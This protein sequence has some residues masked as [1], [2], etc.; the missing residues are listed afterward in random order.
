MNGNTVLHEA[1]N[2]QGTEELLQYL[3]EKQ[4][5]IDETNNKGRTPLHYASRGLNLAAVQFLI[6][7]GAAIN[8][9]DTAKKTP[10]HLACEELSQIDEDEELEKFDQIIEYLLQQDGIEIN[11]Q[12]NEGRVPLHYICSDGT[13]EQIQEFCD[14]R[15]R[16]DI[17][18]N[19][20]KSVVH[21]AY[22]A[23]RR[24]TRACIS[25]PAT[26]RRYPL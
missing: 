12:D 5:P 10:L 14:E 7:A 6:E 22:T 24:A 17:V 3:A 13:M 15:A 21:Y 19:Y 1:S 4:L 23:E 11:S 26:E 18:D 8:S 2:G 9:Q 25:P 20:G 16:L